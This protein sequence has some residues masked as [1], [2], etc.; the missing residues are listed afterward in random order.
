LQD[1]E[2]RKERDLR[3]QIEQEEIRRNIRDFDSK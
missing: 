3:A 1:L 2:Q